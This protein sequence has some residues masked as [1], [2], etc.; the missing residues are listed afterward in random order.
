[1]VRELN[2]S[3]P[4]VNNIEPPVPD[5]NRLEDEEPV[6]VPVPEI[7][8]EIVKD[9]PLRFKT[10]FALIVTSPRTEMSVPRV[11]VPLLIEKL[12]NSVNTVAGILLFAFNCTVPVPQLKTLEV[13]ITENPLH[14]SVPPED[15]SN[16]PFLL[17]DP[18]TA[19]N[20][21]EPLTVNWDPLL[22][23]R[24][25]SP[26]SFEFGIPRT[27]LR[28]TAVL[29]FTVS[30]A[31]LPTTIASEDVGAPFTPE[32][33]VRLAQE[34]FDVTYIVAPYILLSEKAIIKNN[35]M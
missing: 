22:K 31:F 10:L 1:M 34:V 29:I 12:L 17:L 14:I 25:P 24:L 3:E 18:C 15:I 35:A 11:V 9:F 7:E 20:C 27:I 8:P 16:I 28:H 6:T 23:I 4:E 33:P 32:P 26:A 5:I 19:P 21:T 13:C 30:V 2:C